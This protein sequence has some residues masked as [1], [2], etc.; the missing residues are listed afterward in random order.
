MTFFSPQ[1]IAAKNGALQTQSAALGPR[2]EDGGCSEMNGTLNSGAPPAQLE[3]CPAATETDIHANH[4]RNDRPGHPTTRPDSHFKPACQRVSLPAPTDN[5]PPHPRFHPC[6]CADRLGQIGTIPPS[7]TPTPPLPP[8]L[9]LHCALQQPLLRGLI[10]R[11]DH[12]LY[13]LC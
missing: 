5:K 6:A 11:S 12:H 4:N 8:T 10:P 1:Q 2:A 9:P 13:L 7:P 3:P